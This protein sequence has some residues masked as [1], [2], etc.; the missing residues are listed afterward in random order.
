M[1]SEKSRKK[2]IV[3]HLRHIAAALLSSVFLL[4]S[5]SASIAVKPNEAIGSEGAKEALNG[6]LKVARS[7]AYIIRC[8]CHQMY[9]LHSSSWGNSQSRSM[10]RMWNFNR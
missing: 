2:R 1:T 9:C 7:K 4:G 6:A 3:K 5:P 10:Y 8:G